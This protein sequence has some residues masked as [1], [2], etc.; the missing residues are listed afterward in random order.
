MLLT[1]FTRF[2]WDSRFCLHKNDFLYLRSFSN[3][4]KSFISN[5]F[6]DSFP[7]VQDFIPKDRTQTDVLNEKANGSRKI[8]TN[9]PLLYRRG[10]YFV[11]PWQSLVSSVFIS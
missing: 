7:Y 2:T 4:C 5:L 1:T 9:C 8:K 3:N 10:M 11:R 6:A